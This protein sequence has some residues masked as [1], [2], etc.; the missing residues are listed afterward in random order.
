MMSWKRLALG[1]VLLGIAT[2]TVVPFARRSARSVRP[3]TESPRSASTRFD[4][5]QSAALFVGVSHFTSDSVEIVP[6]AVDDAIDLAY[7]FALDRRVGLVP[8]R[9]VVLMLSG[10]PVKQDSRGRLRA[11]QAAGA[12][13]RFRAG[14][15]DINAALREQAALAGRDGMLIV[16]VATHGFLHDGRDY[17]LGASSVVRD[18]A[19]MLSTAD[20]F[21]VI[22]SSVAQRSL[23]FV[24]ACRERM[25]SG[26]RA[27]LANTMSAAPLVRRLG[28][29]RGQAV[30]YA[31][32]AGQWAYDDAEAH[33][34]VFTKAVIDGIHCGAAKVRGDVTAET[35]AGYVER[36]VHTWIRDNRDPNVGSAT[37]VSMDGEARNMVLAQCWGP[38]APSGPVRVTVSGTSIH[39][40]SDKNELLWQR[41]VGAVVMHAEAVDLDAGGIREVVFDTPVAITALDAGGKLLWSAPEAMR[42]TAFITY[43]LF[44]QH[45]NEVVALLNDEHSPASR[46]VI[47]GPDGARLGAFD[48]N[49]HLDRVTVGRPTKR[50][51]PKIIVTSGD[52]LL[53]FDPKKLAAGKPLWAGRVSPRAAGAIASLEIVDCDGDGKSD[54]A[55]TTASG[56]KV[57]VDFTGHAIHS[58]S[59]AH[60]EKELPTTEALRKTFAHRR[61]K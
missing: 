36:S 26:T 60:F 49:R 9:R 21:E 34:G 17:I 5:G 52:T 32:A 24:D 45:T 31:A 29:T 20:M 13:V 33:N 16:S 30:F 25:V 38:L 27:V 8:P 2:A 39:A 47:Y 19:T 55:L 50:H 53:V 56:E 4:R 59:A 22:A 7:V 1:V 37:Q 48:Y 6:Y 51:A 44:R 15:G 57:C 3:V 10:H 11:L 42:V 18:P 40:F 35:L 14:A 54:I 61:E 43:D 12:G 41:G 46:L 28:H 58:H 23:I